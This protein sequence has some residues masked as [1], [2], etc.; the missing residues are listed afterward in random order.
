MSLSQPGMNK[1]A[2]NMRYPDAER[3][4]GMILWSGSM[5]GP[6]AVPGMYK[7]RLTVNGKAMESDFEIL[8]DPRVSVSVADMQAQFDF[9]QSVVAKVSETHV[10][11]RNIRT[12]RDQINRVTEPLRGQGDAMKDV[13]DKAKSIQ[14]AMTAVEEELYQ[15]KNRSGQDPLNFPIRLNNKLAH[16]N[17]LAGN[18]SYPPTEQ[19]IGVRDELT[20]LIDAEL[21]KLKRIFDTEIPAFNALVK[22]KNLDAVTVE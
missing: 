10:A 2:W 15:T 11:I 5:N 14:D 4:D 9:L 22:A 18:G 7:V 19:M 6:L 1:F 12:V 20:V 13:L 16:L 17:S 21:A 3:F 8:K